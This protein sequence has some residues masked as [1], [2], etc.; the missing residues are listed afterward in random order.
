M[1]ANKKVVIVGGVAC[2]PKTAS[3]LKRIVPEAEITMVEKGPIVSYGACGMPYFVA[4]EIAEIRALMETPVG[5]LRDPI[6]FK[7]VKGFETLTQTEVTRIDREG[8]T[9][10]LV[11]LPSGKKETLHYDKLVLAMGTRPFVPPIPGIELK[12]VTKMYHPDDAQAVK[13]AAERGEIKHAVIVGA[14]LIGIE[15]A[16]AFRVRNIE[17][18]VVEML[19]QL[20][21]QLLDEE[22]A[23]LAMK[24]LTDKGVRLRMNEKVEAF[25][26]DG[27]GR[28]RAVKTSNGEIQADLALLSI[29]V[30]PNNKLAGDAGLALDARGGILVN[31]YCQT[32]DPD[33]YAGGDCVSNACVQGLSG[34]FIFAPQGS[35]ANKHGRIIANHIAQRAESFPGVLG[36]VICKA[37]DYTIARTGLTESQARALGYDVETVLWAGTDLPHF[38]PKNKPFCM[39]FIMNRRTRQLVGFQA[40]GAGDV[41]K[42]LDVAA[43]AMSFRA[44]V[45]EMAYLDL[46]YAP[47]YSP[48]LDP[49]LTAAHV[50]QNKLDGIA[51]SISPVELRRRLDRDDGGIVLLDVR[52]PK[53]TEAEQLPYQ[54]RT[55]HI[56]LGAL[57]ERMN[58][59]PKDKWVVPYCKISLRGYEAERILSHAG[60][61]KVSFLESGVVGWP[62]EIIRPKQAGPT[63]TEGDVTP[64]FLREGSGATA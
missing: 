3:R 32:S 46:G 29:G 33:I 5:A 47:P 57:R 44:T 11:H 21:G 25:L 41:D 60:F 12:G 27:Q 9:V 13:E 53:E 61:P 64:P 16:E 14:G 35:T 55:L 28:I 45:D 36:T 26:G 24:H 40:V 4:G 10:D 62:Y 50:A 42:R 20:M 43:T 18:T 38:L 23:R 17:V 37:M 7:N 59:I 6:F 48:P 22:I 1:S 54:D 34:N 58:E 39:K 15:M 52:T 56:P 19:D 51:H 30:R 31:S 8:K 63:E 49:I 2:G